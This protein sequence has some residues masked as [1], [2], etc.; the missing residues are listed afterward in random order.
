M[1]K[2]KEDLLKETLQYVYEQAD[3]WVNKNCNNCA[4]SCF[5]EEGC[6][7]L[8]MILNCPKAP[9]IVKLYFKLK[10]AGLITAIFPF[11]VDLE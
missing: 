4:T 3:E 5:S 7:Y 10:E 8:D 2:K 9:H 1:N 11:M 6:F